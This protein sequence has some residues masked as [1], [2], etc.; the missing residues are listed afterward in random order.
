MLR[1]L[2]VRDKGVEGG[3]LFLQIVEYFLVLNLIVSDFYPLSS[4]LSHRP[5]AAACSIG[6]DGG[7]VGSRVGEVGFVASVV[8]TRLRLLSAYCSEK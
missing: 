4:F 7:I 5:S 1:Y 2:C 6:V 8:R 3:P